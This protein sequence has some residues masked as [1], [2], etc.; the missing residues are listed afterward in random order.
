ML[1]FE[2]LKFEF[3]IP[4]QREQSFTHRE[5]SFTQDRKSEYYRKLIPS[6]TANQNY[7]KYRFELRLEKFLSYI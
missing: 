3:R 4:D 2:F 5:Q 7:Q 1:L 6:I